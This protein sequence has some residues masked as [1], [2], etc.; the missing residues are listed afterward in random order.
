MLLFV[1]WVVCASEVLQCFM[2]IPLDMILSDL[3]YIYIYT[4]VIQ[5][6]DIPHAPSLF[7]Y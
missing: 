3:K 7:V 4:N 6:F 2:P 5:Q 1:C